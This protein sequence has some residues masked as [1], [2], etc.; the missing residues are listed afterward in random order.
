L[1]I[2]SKAGRDDL[3]VV[4]IGEFD[5][6][7]SVEFVESLQ[8]PFTRDEKWVLIVS[9]LFG[10]PIKCTICDAGGF[11]R[12]KLN[13]TQILSQIDY[14]ICRRYRDR[15][16][17]AGKFKIQFARMGEPSFNPA[18]LEVLRLLPQVYRAPGLM[19]CISSIAPAGTE[20]WFDELLA[21]KRNFYTGKFQ[22]Q[23]SIHSTD[24]EYRRKLIPA[25]I[26]DFN[27]IADYGERFLQR[28]DRKITLN[29]APDENC[30]IQPES[31]TS[32]FDPDKFLIKITPL[33]PTYRAGE[34]NFKSYIDPDSGKQNYDL[35]ENLKN[36]GYEVLISIG[37][38]EE[39]Q[40][41]S[42]CGQYLQRHLDQREPLPRGYSY[43]ICDCE[44][45]R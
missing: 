34:G 1:K 15:T 12:G 22:L 6:G 4:Y 21:I 35:V 32:Y 41:G 5:S 7:N 31:L 37:E 26:W 44:Q 24:R 11:Y 16:V 10:C 3:A 43:V 8:P 33:N 14:M 20:H 40:I 18:V 25:R 2:I 17:P 27:Q 36:A 39:N 38:L 30:A 13:A 19:P 28:G 23:F 29:F 42:N 9:V 45:I